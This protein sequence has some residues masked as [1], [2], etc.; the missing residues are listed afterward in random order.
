MSHNSVGRIAIGLR[1]IHKA[2]MIAIALAVFGS[3]CASLPKLSLSR[4]P[5]TPAKQ[6]AFAEGVSRVESRRGLLGRPVAAVTRNDD[7]PAVPDWRDSTKDKL[8]GA[9]ESQSDVAQASY[10]RGERELPALRLTSAQ[11]ESS[12]E[13]SAGGRSLA[14]MMAR[15]GS[16]RVVGVDGPTNSTAAQAKPAP[17]APPGPAPKEPLTTVT[18]A[19]VPNP[20]GAAPMAPAGD[21][22]V[23]PPPA[24]SYGAPVEE[25]PIAPDVGPM[26]CGEGG[27]FAGSSKHC[28]SCGK[29]GCF[30]KCG[31]GGCRTG[32]FGV[33]KGDCGLWDNIVSRVGGAYFDTGTFDAAGAV[34]TLEFSKLLFD[35]GWSMHGGVAV[36]QFDG[37]NPASLSIGFSK[38]ARIEDGCVTRPLVLGVSYDGYYDDEFFGANQ[39]LYVDQLRVLMGWAFSERMDAGVWAAF[40]VSDDNAVFTQGTNILS[41]NGSF[42]DR[43]AGYLSYDLTPGTHTMLSVG[44]QEEPGNFFTQLDL[45]QRVWRNVNAFAS[46]GYA[47]GNNGMWSVFA[48]LEFHP[49]AALRNTGRA[50]ACHGNAGCDLGG[51]NYTQACGTRFRGGQAFGNYRGALRLIDPATLRRM[52][53]NPN[54]TIIGQ[55]PVPGSQEV[56]P[57]TNPKPGT[58]T[59]DC[60]P[61]WNFYQKNESRL[62]RYLDSLGRN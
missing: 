15:L 34:E 60:I 18:P 17:A 3:G 46:F 44:W 52:L 9:S 62:S 23:L 61:R 24:M 16:A 31:A 55:V 48:G 39:T 4:K 56:P 41:M 10:A 5:A 29:L 35:T 7:S 59:D 19:P 47:D 8:S 42:S 36:G 11:L 57:T 58:D 38:L 14:P 40:G 51:N 13:Q 53:N 43:A 27:C 1:S 25:S 12:P 45:Y 6:D 30:G 54:P 50:L 26:A 49:L 20:V 37:Q 32:Q 28:L 22:P 33:T 21:H 2:R